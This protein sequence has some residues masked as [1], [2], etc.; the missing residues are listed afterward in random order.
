MTLRENNLPPVRKHRSNMSKPDRNREIFRRF[1][2]DGKTYEE[3]AAEF[4][5][6]RSRVGQIITR[7][8]AT[9]AQRDGDG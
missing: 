6:T 9:A 1:F 4:G 7:E 3:I 2:E 8:R 5:I